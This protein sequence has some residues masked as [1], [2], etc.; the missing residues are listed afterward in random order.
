MAA[1]IG[2]AEEVAAAVAGAEIMAA[3]AAQANL[4]AAAKAEAIKR[5]WQQQQVML[6]DGSSSS[7]ER[8]GGSS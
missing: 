2:K 4:G 5:R 3:A 6:R 1:A 8:P 7:P